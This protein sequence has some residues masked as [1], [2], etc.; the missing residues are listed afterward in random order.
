MNKENKN[1]NKDRLFVTLELEK[2]EMCE[3]LGHF[4]YIKSDYNNNINAV[5]PF[6]GYMN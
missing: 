2:C 4:T 5:C 3:K 6:C 1:T